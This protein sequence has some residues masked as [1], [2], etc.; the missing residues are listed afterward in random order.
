VTQ[1]IIWSGSQTIEE[2]GGDTE[3]SLGSFDRMMDQSKAWR[4]VSGELCFSVDAEQD[5]CDNE[6][7]VKYTRTKIPEQTFLRAHENYFYDETWR[8]LVPIF[9]P[10]A[11]TWCAA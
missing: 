1:T 5:D 6:D 8:R 2:D 3:P 10:R 7:G 9:S 11:L 4:Q